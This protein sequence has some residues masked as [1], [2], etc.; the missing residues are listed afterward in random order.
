MKKSLRLAGR[1]LLAQIQ[2]RR[3][4]SNA[5]QRLQRSDALRRGTGRRAAADRRLT[6]YEL[7]CLGHGSAAGFIYAG[8]LVVVAPVPGV[9]PVLQVVEP[10][11]VVEPVPVE[12]RRDSS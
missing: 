2:A 3:G 9:E 7:L 6:G 8:G 11:L 5:R 1:R 10:V 4:R 12:G